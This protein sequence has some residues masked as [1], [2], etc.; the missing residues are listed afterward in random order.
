VYLN[1]FA[2]ANPPCPTRFHMPVRPLYWPSL[3]PNGGDS[4]LPALLS[5]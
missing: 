5:S 4:K 3:S 1:F 2:V